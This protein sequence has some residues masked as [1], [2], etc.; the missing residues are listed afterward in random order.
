[1]LKLYEIDRKKLKKIIKNIFIES[2]NYSEN[3][4]VYSGQIQ[5]QLL[6]SPGRDIKAQK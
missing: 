4:K 5:G 1:M 2:N 3:F 6:H